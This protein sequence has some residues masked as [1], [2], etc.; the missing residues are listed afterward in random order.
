MNKEKELPDSRA[1]ESITQDLDNNMVVEAGAGSGKTYSLVER[2]LALIGTGRTRIKNIAAVT[3]TRKA[4][5]EMQERFQLALEEKVSKTKDSKQKQLFQIALSKL[6]QAFIGTIHSFC[7]RLLRERPIEAGIDPTFR[8]LDEFTEISMLEDSWHA[9]LAGL[10]SEEDTKRLRDFERFGINVSDLKKAFL[11][12]CSY[13][14]VEIIHT[15]VAEPDLSEAIKEIDK[16]IEESEKWIPEDRPDG[17]YD[18]LQSCIRTGKGMIKKLDMNV[19]R[20]R[21]N[22]LRLFTKNRKPTQKKWNDKETAKF[23]GLEYE[24]LRDEIV[25]PV[26]TKWREFCHDAVIRFV[27]PATQYAREYRFLRGWLNYQDLLMEAAKLLREKPEVRAYFKRHYTHLI[28]DEFQDTDPIQAE[29]IFFLCG[30]AGSLRQKNWR[31]VVLEKG[32]LF[33]VG[34]PK[35]S[36]YRFRRADISTYNEVKKLVEKHNG[37]IVTLTSNFR[38]NIEIGEWVTSMFKKIFPEK[39]TDY[40]PAFAPV[41][42]FRKP[43]PDAKTSGVYKLEVSSD[44]KRA[45]DNSTADMVA[46]I[47]A[48]ALNKK[49][50]WKIPDRRN[51]GKLRSVHPGDFMILTIKKEPLSIYAGALEKYSIPYEITGAKLNEEETVLNEILLLTEAIA[52]PEDPVKLL[53]V[54]RCPLYGISDKELY[55]FSKLGGIFNFLNMPPK[56]THE[57]ICCAIKQLQKFCE[58]TQENSPLCAFEKIVDELG[59]I[60]FEISQPLG[61]RR[62][63]LILRLLELA[64]SLSP[65]DVV[66][67]SALVEQLRKLVDSG[68]AADANCFTSSENVV[69]VM[70]LHKAKGLEAGIVFLVDPLGKWESDPEFHVDRI[71]KQAKG[72]FFVSIKREHQKTAIAQPPGWDNISLHEK[73][74]LNAERSRLS[75]VAATRAADVLIVCGVHGKED[76]NPWTELYDS[77]P[78]NKKISIP[79][80]QIIKQEEAVISQELLD[81]VHRKQKERLNIA[82]AE[83]FGK[84]SVVKEIKSEFIFDSTKS[85]NNERGASWG[86]IIHCALEALGKGINGEKLK[87]LIQNR[88]VQE[89]RSINELEKVMGLLRKIESSDLWKRMLVSQKKLFEVPFAI[90]TT[91]GELGQKESNPEHPIILTGQIDLTFKEDNG[92]VIVDYKTD[93]IKDNLDE[94]VAHYTPQLKLYATYWSK[95][96][97]QSIA[98]TILYFLS[99]NKEVEVNGCN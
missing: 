88:L 6:E 57:G 42:A 30:E 85:D 69:R 80:I 16:F 10:T 96:T 14:D 91:A 81:S 25:A 68:A 31:K 83:S 26:L 34:D 29:I 74:F 66:S 58:W 95:I 44:K 21:V 13:P 62:G 7:A 98:E 61:M 4:A 87:I 37:K 71:G 76:K 2:M 65:D 36:I 33:I 56:N 79:E 75:Y 28:V 43:L 86:R 99:A 41:Q 90:C 89:E 51:E 50:G 17:G 82:V 1:R 20:N 12:V 63:G 35:Q 3:F 32:R 77:I 9:Y 73:E 8:E 22:L 39:S 78:D 93:V 15:P 55:L 40:Q 47:I 11:K 67:F 38:S 24:K 19:P 97:G 5:A 59:I 54:L 92:W 94:L 48:D 46:S 18:K 49:N 52:D 53:G 84:T 23:L 60:P 70:N 72:Y 45:V 64:R 27:K